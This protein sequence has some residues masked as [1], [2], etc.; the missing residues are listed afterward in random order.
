MEKIRSTYQVTDGNLTVEYEIVTPLISI[1]DKTNVAVFYK[2]YGNTLEDVARLTNHADGCDCA[3]AV[4]SGLLAGMLDIV[5]VGDWNFKEAKAQSNTEINKKVIA[6][7]KKHPDYDIYCKTTLENLKKKPPEKPNPRKKPKDPN[8]LETAIEFLEYK[9]HLPGDGA[10]KG[11]SDI[12]PKTHR[13]DDFCHH[14][15]IVGLVCCIIV[16]FTGKTFYVNSAGD[17]IE[18]PIEI[19]EKGDFVGK[20]LGTKVFCGFINWVIY[21]AKLQKGHLMSDIATPAGVPGSLLSMVTELASL[22]CFKDPDFLKKLRNLYTRGIGNGVNQIDLGIFNKLFEGA[23]S[24]WDERTELAVKKEL[25]RQAIP[26]IVNEAIVRGVYAV[27]SF[28]KEAKAHSHIEE[29]NWKAIVPFDNRTVVRMMTISTG[30]MEAV[31]IADAS[32]RAA[33][34]SGGNVGV[35]AEQM[36]VRVNFVGIGR[37]AIAGMT[38][39]SM[40]FKRTRFEYALASAEVAIAADTMVSTT[41][42]TQSLKQITADNLQCLNRKTKELSSLKF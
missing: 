29:F 20:N 31:D 6:F 30:T 17:K 25:R 18:I 40:E 32:I 38:D 7:A 22:P 11:R 4:T 12:T 16:Q 21:V 14:P 36:V 3:L 41:K 35:F 1:E 10:Y 5:F 42:E 19:D 28:I 2:D 37:F 24:K 8:R 23:S 15:T 26:V 13:L 27:R 39:M 34:K 9:Y 33:L